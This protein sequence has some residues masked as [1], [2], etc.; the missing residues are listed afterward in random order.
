MFFAVG[1]SLFSCRKSREIL[2]KGICSLAEKIKHII[3]KTTEAIRLY[4]KKP[5]TL[6]AVILLTFVCQGITILGYAILAESMGIEADFKIYFIF[7]PISWLIG[8]LPITPGGVGVMEGGLV[9]LLTTVAKLPAEQALVLALAQRIIIMLT[10]LP[11]A[12]VHLFGAHLPT[13]QIEKQI[14]RAD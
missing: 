6:T 14:E 8:A 2:I 13:E 7:F 11:G 12:A 9:F 10:S 3:L 4:S 1:V 5:I